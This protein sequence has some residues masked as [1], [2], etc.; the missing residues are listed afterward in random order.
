[1]DQCGR[2]LPGGAECKPQPALASQRIAQCLA[3]PSSTTMAAF[4]KG[5]SD[6]APQSKGGPSGWQGLALGNPC[7]CPDSLNFFLRFPETLTPSGTA[8]ADPHA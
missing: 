6:L 3:T 1:M 5:C 2:S 7:S 4:R 8:P